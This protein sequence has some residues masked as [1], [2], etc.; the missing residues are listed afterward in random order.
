MYKLNKNSVARLADGAFIPFANGNADYEEY[1]QW[2]E[3]GNTPEPEFTEKEI[4]A[5]RI[6][7]IK[8]KAGTLILSKYSIE[9]Q[10]SANLGIYGQEYL[11]TMKAFIAEVIKQSNELEADVSKTADDFVIGA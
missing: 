4:E 8:A 7:S 5:D 11:D 1:K 6:Q 9:K 3:E 10:S 2:L